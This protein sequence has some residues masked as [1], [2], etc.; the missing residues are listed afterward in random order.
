MRTLLTKGSSFAPRLHKSP[1]PSLTRHQSEVINPPLNT[2]KFSDGPIPAPHGRV[3]LCSHRIYL[4][5]Q[6]RCR[7]R[8]GSSHPVYSIGHS[9]EL[10]GLPQSLPHGLGTH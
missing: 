3:A 2:V 9:Q 5:S 4:A 1:G 7:L 8:I 10:E 6:G